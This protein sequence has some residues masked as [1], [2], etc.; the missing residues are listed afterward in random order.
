M[1]I[2]VAQWWC[3]SSGRNGG[4]SNSGGGGG[5]AGGG[6]GT[7]ASGGKVGK[8]DGYGKVGD[9]EDRGGRPE[10]PARRKLIGPRVP[11]VEEAL[12]TSGMSGE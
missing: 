9:E 2:A 3:N 5:S 12:F 10:N 7:A 4:G 11:L 8:R 6:G 1:G